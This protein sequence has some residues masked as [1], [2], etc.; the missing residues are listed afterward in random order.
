M[1]I[2]AS[3]DAQHTESVVASAQC[4]DTEQMWGSDH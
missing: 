4:L 3:L 1:Q 2:L